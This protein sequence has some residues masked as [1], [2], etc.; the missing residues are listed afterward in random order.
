MGTAPA[1]DVGQSPIMGNGGPD[2]DLADLAPALG[3]AY[4]NVT[5]VGSRGNVSG[6]GRTWTGRVLRTPRILP[7][8]EV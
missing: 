1:V 8:F 6:A 2:R 7:I 3:L 5:P 4:R